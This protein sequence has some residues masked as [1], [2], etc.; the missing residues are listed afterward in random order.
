M[1]HRPSWQANRF[2]PSQEISRVLWKAKDYYY[3]HNSPP[4]VPVLNQID[5]VCAPISLLEDPF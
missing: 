4:P 2:W 1:E 5:P 3:I